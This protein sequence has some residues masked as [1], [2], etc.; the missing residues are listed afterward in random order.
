MEEDK[1]ILALLFKDNILRTYLLDYIKYI[2]NTDIATSLLETSVKYF[3]ESDK[4]LNVNFDDLD[5]IFISE[6]DVDSEEIKL[7]NEV[8][9][10]SFSDIDAVKKA[11][12]VSINKKLKEYF[13][14]EAFANDCYDIDKLEDLYSLLYEIEHCNEIEQTVEDLEFDNIEDC[15]DSFDNQKHEGVTF[16]DERVSNNLAAKQFDCGTIN[17]IVGAPGRG[18]TQLILNQSV[19]VAKNKQHTLHIA[20]GDLTKR[21]LLL[22]LLAI[23]TKKPIQQ[24]SM[25]NK[26]QFKNFLAKVKQKY[27]DI[28]VYLHSK[29]CLPNTLTGLDLIRKIEESQRKNNV[30]YTQIVIDY[31]GNIET[32]ISTNNKRR[33]KD[34]NKSM[35]YEGADIYN[36]F[37]SFAKKNNSVIWML[38]QPKVQ[39]WS[40]EKIP[41][42]ALSDSSK[43]G[44]IIDF[45][46][47]IGKKDVTEE[48]CTFFCSKNRHGNA[49]FTLHSRQIGDSQTFEPITDGDW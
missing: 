43:K 4:S 10:I 19:H 27:P 28:F 42:E 21:Q 49:N 34:D 38:S 46:M 47:S 6:F 12:L 37:V 7:W 13:F 32:S 9:T 30:H 5:A 1:I 3:S 15:C 20:I 25:L 29:V 23:I 17:V 45:C 2:C 33:L 31:D 22:R 35:Y 14:A 48:Q 41:L 36:N 44:H 39:Y 18:K 11:T 26:E 8:K 24:I 16:F 40:M